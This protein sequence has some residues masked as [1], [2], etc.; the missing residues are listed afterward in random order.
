MR[1]ALG[2]DLGGTKMAIGVIDEQQSILHRSTETTAGLTLDELLDG[3]ERELRDGLAACPQVNAVGI[4][5]PCTIAR[6]SGYAIGAVNLPINDVPFRDLM[7]ERIGLPVAIDNDANVAALAEHRFGAARGT[8]NAIVLTIGTGIGGG[9]II[10]GELYRGSSGAGAEL[11][12]VVID[13]SGPPCQGNCPNRGCVET[14]ASGT[15]LGREGDLAAQSHPQSA[16]GKA[17]AEG[18]E[19]D[20]RL[21][22]EA[23]IAGDGI[24][25]EVLAT[26]GRRLGVALSSLANIFEPE[27]IVIGGGVSAAGELLIGPARDELRSRA[28]KPM[29]ADRRRRRR[30]RGRRRDDRRRRDGTRGNRLMAGRLTVCPTPIGNVEDISIRARRVLEEADLVACEDTRRAGRL[31]ERLEISRPRLVSYH[32]QNE[33]ERA[34]QLAQQ[35]ERGLKVVLISDAGTPVISDPG[36]RLI[37]TCVERDLEVEVL[38]GPSAVTTALVASALPGRSLALRGLPAAPRR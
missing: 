1:A 13:Q 10:G 22:T 34:R 8:R 30:A 3:L 27:V 11:G 21:V 14:L 35:I 31:Y 4:G 28:L 17:L 26:I 15:A 32:D 7:H 19:V 9:L 6:E 20:G 38:P 5:I 24:A 2:A 18:T 16:L 36:Y 33:S 12:H 29:N 23:A 25:V 37:R